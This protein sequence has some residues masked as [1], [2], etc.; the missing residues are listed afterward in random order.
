MGC[1]LDVVHIEVCIGTYYPCMGSLKGAIVEDG[2]RAIAYALVRL[3]LN[4]FCGGAFGAY[5]GVK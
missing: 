5:W 1:F 2:K 4:V 3:P